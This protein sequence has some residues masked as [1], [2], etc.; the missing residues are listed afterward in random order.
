[1]LDINK[2]Q[3]FG[4]I[5]SGLQATSFSASTVEFFMARMRKMSNH[6]EASKGT[7]N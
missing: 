5:G 6:R 4:S 7:R 2:G 1:M 3:G